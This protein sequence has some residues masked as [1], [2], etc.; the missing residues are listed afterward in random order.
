MS[1]IVESWDGLRWLIREGE[2]F[3]HDDVALSKGEW[4]V[5]Q[6]LTRLGSKSLTFAD[7]GAHVGFYAVRMSRIF[8]EVYAFEPN[9][10]SVECMKTN[11]DL[12]QVTNA[13]IFQVAVGDKAEDGELYLLGPSSSFIPFS[14]ATGRIRVKIQR[15]D[16]LIEG[17]DVI[18][19]DVEGWEEYALAGAERILR[20]SKP[21]L[22]IEHHEYRGYPQL[23]GMHERINARLND[24]VSLGVDGA[25][26]IY[27]PKGSDL[28]PLTYAVVRCWFE[29]ILRNVRTHEP[30]YYGFPYTWWWGLS[31]Y[32]F[33]TELPKHVLTEEEWFKGAAAHTWEEDA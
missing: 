8:K 18:K 32:G 17:V 28:S 12:N 2:Q 4:T 10:L 1:K 20:D 31:P 9:P 15:L 25:H 23:K 16:D 11:L 13:K 29:K 19:L 30:W 3:S 14:E 33:I 5:L 6:T 7:V 21:V 22:I 24:H 26:W 27:M